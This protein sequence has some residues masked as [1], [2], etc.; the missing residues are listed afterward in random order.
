MDHTDREH[1][2]LSKAILDIEQ[3]EPRSKDYTQL[4]WWDLCKIVR[5][6]MTWESFDRSYRDYKEM[7]RQ[8]TL[9]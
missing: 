9:Q 2:E 7:K 3:S 8:R 6:S 1:I 4:D 5:P